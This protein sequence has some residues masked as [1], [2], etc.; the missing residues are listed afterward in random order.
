MSPQNCKFDINQH[1]CQN[2]K[3]IAN[4]KQK[5]AFVKTNVFS[6][7]SQSPNLGLMSPFQNQLLNLMTI[8]IYMRNTSQ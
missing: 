2:S 7:A 1:L 4:S 8:S 6:D 3:R 5:H